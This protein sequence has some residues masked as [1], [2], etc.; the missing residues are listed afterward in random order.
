MGHEI[1]HKSKNQIYI[2]IMSLQQMR[3]LFTQNNLCA[4]YFLDG[5]KKVRSCAAKVNTM[6]HG[7]HMDGYVISEINNSWEVLPGNNKI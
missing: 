6:K 2:H 7:L 5:D 3:Y 4:C 1:V